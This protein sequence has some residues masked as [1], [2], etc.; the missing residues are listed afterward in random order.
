MLKEKYYRVGERPPPRGPLSKRLW[1]PPPP[2]A[3]TPPEP[4]SPQS[5]RRS[6]RL[7]ARRS[8]RINTDTPNEPDG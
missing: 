1:Q 7:T 5:R 6:R 3:A 2:A 8:L 4:E